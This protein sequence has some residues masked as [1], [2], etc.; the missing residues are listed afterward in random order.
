MGCSPGA[1]LIKNFRELYRYR[2]LL[3]SLVTRELGA[4][5]RASVLGFLWTFLNPA[6]QM[7]VY[8]LIFG[9]A[10][11]QKTEHYTYFLFV[12]LL[13][14]LWLSSS[15]TAG[16]SSISD[17]RDLL[18][19]VRFPP[20]VLPM[21]IIVAN[22]VNYILALPLMFALGLAENV[23]PSWTII[24]LP[25]IILVQFVFTAAV[26]YAL[27]AL[28]VTFRDLQHL[29]T[30]VIQLFFFL[31]PVVWSL[32]QLPPHLQKWVVTLNPMAALVESYRRIFLYHQLPDFLLLT[33]VFLVGVIAL[34]LAC[35]LF[36]AR[37]EDFAEL[38]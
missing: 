15:I 27:S 20:Q 21:T 5:Y 10:L 33:K 9:Y 22:M 4:R 23:I 32:T 14:W 11:K 25:L 29:T 28:N 8:V 6:L 17:R 35:W 24:A 36:E 1:H 12:G 30:N 13:P 3:W 26:V 37:R 31:T 19:K 7:V 38:V 18:T 2:A 16:V 34:Q